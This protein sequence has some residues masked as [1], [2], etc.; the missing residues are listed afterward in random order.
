MT[1]RKMELS[2]IE[3]EDIAGLG[4]SRSGFNSG[5]LLDPWEHTE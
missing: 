5:C 3:I 4:A 2:A 1:G